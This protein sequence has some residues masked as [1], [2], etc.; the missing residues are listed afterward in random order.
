MFYLVVKLRLTI[1]SF[2]CCNPRFAMYDQQYTDRLKE[3]L[4]TAGVEADISLVHATEAQM[5]M[6]FMYMAEIFPLIQNMVRP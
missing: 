2:A 6:R 3:V 4:R 5:S 1:L